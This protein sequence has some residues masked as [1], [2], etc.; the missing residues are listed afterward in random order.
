MSASLEELDISPA[1]GLEQ[2]AVLALGQRNR[3]TT[4][5]QNIIILGSTGS[6]KSFLACAFGAVA[7]RNA[8]TVRYHLTSHQLNTLTQVRADNP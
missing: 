7:V 1:R 3:I 2:Q 6:G 5:L 4:T 8:F